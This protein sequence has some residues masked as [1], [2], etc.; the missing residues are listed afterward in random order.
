VGLPYQPVRARSG[1]GGI[2]KSGAP[3][4]K[5]FLLYPFPVMKNTGLTPMLN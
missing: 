3:T 5:K 1:N 4:T 2:E